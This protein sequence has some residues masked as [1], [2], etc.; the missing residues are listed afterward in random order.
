[1][2]VLLRLK[3]PRSKLIECLSLGRLWRLSVVTLLQLGA[4]D[5][6]IVAEDISF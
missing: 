5:R 2:D 4:L 6:E 1:M 3:C